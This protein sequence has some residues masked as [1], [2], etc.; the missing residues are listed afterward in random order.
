MT[1]LSPKPSP[2]KR[3]RFHPNSHLQQHHLPAP[4]RSPADVF[5]TGTTT[6]TNTGRTID[7]NANSNATAASVGVGRTRGLGGS[8]GGTG[9][10]VG[11]SELARRSVVGGLTGSAKVQDQNDGLAEKAG[12]GSVSTSTSTSMGALKGIAGLEAKRSKMAFTEG[13]GTGTT[14][15]NVNLT[16]VQSPFGN[17]VNGSRS[18]PV[19]NGN[20][21]NGASTS[22]PRPSLTTSRSMTLEPA[23]HRTTIPDPFPTPDVFYDPPAGSVKSTHQASPFLSTRSQVRPGGP[24]TGTPFFKPPAPPSLSKRSGTP[25]LPHAKPSTSTRSALHTLPQPG[26][27]NLHLNGTGSN[28]AAGPSANKRRKTETGTIPVQTLPP[29]SASQQQAQAQA[30]RAKDESHA[31]YKNKY[32]KAF[33]SFVFCF[34]AEFLMNQNKRGAAGEKGYSV[35]DCKEGIRRMGGVSLGLAC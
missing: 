3:A 22:T 25:I 1:T 5:Y 32:T 2:F 12:P 14:S 34:D 23:R 11:M 33:P 15:G 10:Q 21:K 29:L 31:D 26:I 20:S 17:S 24:T 13:T 9:R 8:V 35:K 7:V 28:A 27:T 18:V 19:L 16:S 6:N 30:Q 4:I